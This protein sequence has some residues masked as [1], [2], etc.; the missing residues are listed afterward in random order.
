MASAG[1]GRQLFFLFALF[2]SREDD[3]RIL[4]CLQGTSMSPLDL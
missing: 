1:S 3:D 2:L 4:V